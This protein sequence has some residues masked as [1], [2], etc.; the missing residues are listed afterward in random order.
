MRY[1]T[2]TQRYAAPTTTISTT[3][4]TSAAAFNPPS[5]VVV[6]CVGSVSSVFL[7]TFY[8]SLS[9]PSHRSTKHTRASEY[10]FNNIIARANATAQRERHTFVD[11]PTEIRSATN[12]PT[13]TTHQHQRTT[14][15]YDDTQN[16][17]RGV[18]AFQLIR[19]SGARARSAARRFRVPRVPRG[20]IANKCEHAPELLS[21]CDCVVGVK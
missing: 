21:A 18:G 12:T 14:T 15:A 13:N 3:L 19:N 8:S 10:E 6:G 2:N 4:A 17:R 1:Y 7:R 9:S 11:C 20:A 16:R 5:S